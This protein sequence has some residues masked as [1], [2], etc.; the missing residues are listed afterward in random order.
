[1]NMHK[2]LHLRDNVNRLYVSKKEGGRRLASIE[3]SVDASIQRLEDYVEKRRGWLFT[4]TWNN[5]DDT[6]TNWMEI[7]RKQKWKDN[8]SVDVLN[9]YE[10]TSQTRKYG[11]GY[12]CDILREKLNLF[13]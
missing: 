4:A 7:T 2:S 12:E 11:R 9:Y 10:A 13:K 5:T 6:K 8:N 3:D 1:M